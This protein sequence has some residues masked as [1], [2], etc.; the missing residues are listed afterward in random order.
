MTGRICNVLLFRY[1]NNCIAAFTSL[2]L[3]SIDRLSLGNRLRGIGG[4]SGQAKVG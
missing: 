3:H 1:L 4:S 2:P